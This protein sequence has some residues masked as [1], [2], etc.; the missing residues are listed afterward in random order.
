MKGPA[1]RLLTSVLFFLERCIFQTLC[2]H[3]QL[4]PQEP[5]TKPAT[6][7]TL[8]TAGKGKIRYVCG[9]VIAKLKRS[10]SEKIKNSLYVKGKQQQLK[11][12]QNQMDILNSLCA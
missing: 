6:D 9:Y 2:T 3:L 4:T 5:L 11:Y 1:L 10:L 8:D 12:Q 7:K